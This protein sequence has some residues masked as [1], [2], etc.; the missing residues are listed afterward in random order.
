[1]LAHVQHKVGM[2]EH[3]NSKNFYGTKTNSDGKVD[4]L[5][6]STTCQWSVSKFVLKEE[7]C[8]LLQIRM[9]RNKEN[10]HVSE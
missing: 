3:G 2:E 7:A 6:H 10:D 8:Y 1:M 9:K 4:T 5:F